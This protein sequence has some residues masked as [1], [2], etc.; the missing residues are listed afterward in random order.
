MRDVEVAAVDLGASSGRVIH[1]RVGADRLDL[2]AVARFENTPVRLPDGLHWNVLELYRRSVQGLAAAESASGPTGLTSIGIDSWA[3]DYGL[4]RGDRLLGQPFHYRDERSAGGVERVRQVVTRE[5][6]FARSGLQHLDFTTVHQLAVDPLVACADRALLVPDLLGW[7]LCGQQVAERTNASTTGLLDV[8]TGE[9]DTELVERLGLATSLFPHLV[10]PGTRLGRLRPAVRAEVPTDAVVVSVASHDTASAV[11]GVPMTEPGAAYVSCGTWGLVGVE[12]GAPV[13]SEAARDANFTNERGVDG[14]TR[15]LTN[16]MGT[17]LLSETLRSWGADG[18]GEVLQRLLAEASAR[19]D[20]GVEPTLFD[21]QDPRFVRPGNMPARI[22]AWCHEHDVR[23]PA[24][25]AEVV[26]AVVASLADAFAGA[27]R[28][29]GELAGVDVDRIHVVGGGSRNE[30]LCRLLAD[31]AGVPVVAG[32]VEA[33]AIGNV[34]AQGRAA[35]ALRGS[36]ESLR[37]LVARTQPLRT[38]MPQPLA[39]RSRSG[40]VGA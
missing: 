5:E 30:L 9:W 40:K 6:H 29:A 14:R 20:A 4:L 39:E 34:L 16:V 24:G 22:A 26:H 13:L 19:H 11:L 8:T 7:W 3:I 12:T 27:A 18:T 31:R 21:V 36:L 10:D 2:D 28:A 33:T 32:P 17:W 1:A 37:D 38:W 23:A 25:Q 35:G 15:F